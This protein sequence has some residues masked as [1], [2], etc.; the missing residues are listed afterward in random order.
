MSKIVVGVDGTEGARHAI[1][2]A[3]DYAKPADTVVLLHSWEMPVAV[4]RMTDPT[5]DPDLV[6]AKATE[7]VETE[8]DDVGRP[9]PDGPTIEYDVREGAPVRQLIE[10]AE[11][12]DLIVIGSRG[13]GGFMGVL[14][15]SV[16]EAV[17]H[18]AP[19]PVVVIPPAE[20]S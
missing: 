18:H 14:V 16:S 1:R 11:D 3:L 15:G 20:A 4:Q 10:A 6:G 7:L 17:V 5:V 13:I 9:A 2:W 8:L 12:A 19:C